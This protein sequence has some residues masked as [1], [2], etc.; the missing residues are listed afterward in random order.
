MVSKQDDTGG[1]PAYLNDDLSE[2]LL[3]PTPRIAAITS[4]RWMEAY[5][6]IEEFELGVRIKSQDAI[7]PTIVVW[8]RQLALFHE[9]VVD[10][11]QR[12]ELNRES[13]QAL[14]F[15][16]HLLGL[17][18][19]TS[20]FALDGM[21]GGHYNGSLS[22]CRNLL[23]TWR[24]AAYARLSPEDIW[25][26]YPQKIWPDDVV[27]RPEG[28]MP[29]AIPTACDIK[30]KIESAGDKADKAI[31]GLVRTGFD[32]LNQHVHPTIEGATQNWDNVTK[33]SG[34]YPRGVIQIFVNRS[35]SQRTGCKFA[36]V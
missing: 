25:R 24:R 14:H 29:K 33:S 22:L 30:A 10:V 8:M 31:L 12:G 4:P 6:R 18:I 19:S 35:L 2:F 21:L 27:P 36:S 15:R 11:F 17:T 1:P 20:K 26:W 34:P 7:Y 23:E 32:S 16:V 28:K 5:S 3:P 13:W 9:G